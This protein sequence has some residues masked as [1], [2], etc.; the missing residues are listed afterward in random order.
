M[1]SMTKMT[2]QQDFWFLQ[3]AHYLFAE[4]A[5]TTAIV[6]ATYKE[7]EALPNSTLLRFDAMSLVAEWQVQS[8]KK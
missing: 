5:D 1:V 7:A 4:L 3:L 6:T 2:R 8:R